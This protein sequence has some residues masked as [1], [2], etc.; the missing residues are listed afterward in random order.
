M[1]AGFGRTHRLR[2]AGGGEWE[3]WL[4]G[5]QL[6]HRGVKSDGW[7]ERDWREPPRVYE[8]KE[9]GGRRTSRKSSSPR[10]ARRRAGHGARSAGRSSAGTGR[11]PDSPDSCP[12]M[13]VAHP[14]NVPTTAHDTIRFIQEGCVM[15]SPGRGIGDCG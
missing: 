10:S 12:L 9:K 11:T 6:Y 5:A 4:D 8:M 13:A 3:V 14:Q 15:A 1:R 2:R 7:I